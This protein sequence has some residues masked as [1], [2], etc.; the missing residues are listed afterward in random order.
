MAIFRFW[1]E[2]PAFSLRS[3]C[4]FTDFCYNSALKAEMVELVDA[5]DSKSGAARRGGSIPPLG[6]TCFVPAAVLLPRII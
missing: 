3:L 1:A 5:P 6:T 4:Y 2:N